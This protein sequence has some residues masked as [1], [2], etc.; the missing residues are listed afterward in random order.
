[1]VKNGIHG[2]RQQYNF[3]TPTVIPGVGHLTKSEAYFDP[4][5]MGTQVTHWSSILPSNGRYKAYENMAYDR[6]EME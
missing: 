2:A 4:T 6:H 5:P 1:M 3:N